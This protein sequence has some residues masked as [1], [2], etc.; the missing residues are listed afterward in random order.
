[1]RV[2]YDR[3][4]VLLWRRCDR[5]CISGENYKQDEYSEGRDVDEESASLPANKINTPVRQSINTLLAYCKRVGSWSLIDRFLKNP[6]KFG[7][8]VINLER[9][10]RERTNTDSA[11][12]SNG[13][14]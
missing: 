4:S 5:L 3:G 14:N 9:Y 7:L 12:V 11:G 6:N 10:R 1:V 13:Y 8:V 2:A